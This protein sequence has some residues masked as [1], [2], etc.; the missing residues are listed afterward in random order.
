M[1]IHICAWI[2]KQ[3]GIQTGEPPKTGRVRQTTVGRPVRLQEPPPPFTDVCGY[4]CSAGPSKDKNQ[5]SNYLLTCRAANEGVPG[6]SWDFH[7]LLIIGVVE[8]V[9]C[10]SNRSDRRCGV[11]VCY[12]SWAWL[13]LVKSHLILTSAAPSLCVP[14]SDVAPSS[15]E[16]QG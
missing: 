2:K 8:G 13:C 12:L 10:V 1:N 3:R 14:A 15:C 4:I 7:C 5:R 16:W 9:H 11:K 6:L